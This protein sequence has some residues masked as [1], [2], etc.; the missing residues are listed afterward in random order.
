MFMCCSPPSGPSRSCRRAACETRPT[1]IEVDLRGARR[2]QRSIRA[3]VTP[4]SPPAS[5]APAGRRSGRGRRRAPPCRRATSSSV[6][7]SVCVRG[8]TSRRASRPSAT[9]RRGPLV[10]R[11]AARRR[12]A[13]SAPPARPSA[14]RVR[15]RP[16][17]RRRGRCVAE[18]PRAS[19]A[20]AGQMLEGDQLRAQPWAIAAAGVRRRGAGRRD[21]GQA[22]AESPAGA[23]LRGSTA[24]AIPGREAESLSRAATRRRPWSE[25]EA[26]CSFWSACHAYRSLRRGVCPASRRVTRAGPASGTEGGAGGGAEAEAFAVAGGATKGSGMGA[27]APEV[28]GRSTGACVA[29]TASV[30]ESF[31]HARRSAPAARTGTTR[32]RRVEAVPP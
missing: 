9:A 27:A 5:A 18:T 19:S 12:R 28:D 26:I 31:E 2:Q 32:A 25:L 22:K 24:I 14:R 6:Y 23:T 3:G 10:L 11:A 30:F 29:G 8:R 21:H 20:L 13:A 17:R 15:H 1:Q 7:V 16:R 4:G